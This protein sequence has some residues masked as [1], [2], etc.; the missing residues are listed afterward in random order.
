MV[1]DSLRGR[2]AECI[3]TFQPRELK[4]VQ[5]RP[6]LSHC[7]LRLSTATRSALVLPVQTGKP[8]APT[9]G[10]GVA[11]P[12]RSSIVKQCVGATLAVAR[13]SMHLVALCR[14]RR[15][16]R[17][18]QAWHRSPWRASGGSLSF[19][20]ERKGGKNAA[21]TDGFGFLCA[22]VVRN[23]PGPLQPR[24]LKTVQTRPVLSHCLLRLSTATR[25][26]L[27]LPVQTGKPFAPTGGRGGA[28][29]L[30]SSIVKQCV[31]ATLAVAR[32][33]MHLVTLCRG[34]RP[35]RPAPSL[36]P[37]PLACLR[38]LPFFLRQKKGGE[39]PP[40]PMVLDS[41]RG[42][43]C[44]MYRDLFSPAN[45]KRYKP[46]LC[47]RIAF[48]AYPPRRAPRL[49]CLSKQGSPLRLPAGGAEPRPYEALSL[50]Q[51]VGATLA[52]ACDLVTEH[53]SSPPYSRITAPLFFSARP[54][55]MSARVSSK[56]SLV[57]SPVFMSLQA[58][59]P[60]AISSPPRK[61]T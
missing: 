58:T 54:D 45:L 13:R 10:R 14:G 22:G 59:T 52:V 32:Q 39:T 29:P 28:P 21:K 15:P 33:S 4:T 34:R 17:P 47:F 1:L 26:A 61:I 5:T 53:R 41:L 35:R 31:G 36:A 20:G 8:F 30:R 11:P 24:E 38:R 2:G 25:S 50:K 48:C 51:C 12:L 19:C 23:V 7:L 37:F 56:G 44:G 3:R 9:G 55:W 18:A 49:C 40:K 46:A 16:R 60:A 42:R 57:C 43:W 6:V 27:V